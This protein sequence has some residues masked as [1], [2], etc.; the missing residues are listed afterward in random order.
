MRSSPAIPVYRT[1]VALAA[2]ALF[3]LAFPPP[4]TTADTPDDITRMIHAGMT[5]A[6]EARVGKPD[7]A[8]EHHW[9]AQ[10]YTRRA[11]STADPQQQRALWTE[12]DRHYAA[13][14]KRLHRATIAGGPGAVVLLAAARVE[15]GGIILSSQVARELDTYLIT[16]GAGG[17]HV[18]L[19]DRFAHARQLYVAAEQ[20][21]APLLADADR[22]EETLLAAGLYDT[23]RR[24]YFDLRLNHGW[25]CYYLAL[26]TDNATT[27]AT[28]LATA[29]G[30]FRELLSA[31]GP[32]QMRWVG[33]L[34][35]AM[36]QREQNHLGDAI[37]Q[38]TRALDRADALR[39][40]ARIRYELA[41]AQLRSGQ[42]DSARATLRPLVNEDPQQL[43]D[44]E[45]AAFYVNL[46]HLWHANSYLREAAW[47]ER[48][49]RQS[50]NPHHKLQDARRAQQRGLARFRE[51]EARGG[52]WPALVR[53]YVAQHIDPTQTAD[54]AAPLE[55]Y[56]AARALADR[57]ELAAAIDRLQTAL[58][59]S[60]DETLVP[61]LLFELGRC[62][63][64]QGALRSAARAFDQL[65]TE[66]RSNAR[67][68]QAATYAYQLW[69]RVA[70][71]SQ[72]P[73]DYANLA[74]TLRNLLESF[75][76]HADHTQA[77]WLL[78]AA[79]ERAGRFDDAA[80]QFAK[81]PHDHPRAAQ[82][83]LRHL[84]CQR[85]ALDQHQATLGTDRYHS[86]AIQLAEQLLA[87]AR[88]TRRAADNDAQPA[89]RLRWSAE[90]CVAAAELLADPRV[91]RYEAA[92]AALADFEQ[93]YPASDRTGNV[94][95]LRIRAHRGQQDFA[96]AAD[97]LQRYLAQAPADEIGGTLAALAQ[98]VHDE[99]DRLLAADHPDDA[100]ALA[101]SA[102]PT[103]I[104]LDEWVCADPQRAQHRDV[105][106]FA[107]ARMHHAAGQLDQALRAINELRARGPDNGRYQQRYARILTDLLAADANATSVQQVRDA[108]AAL[109]ADP[110]LRDRAP[111]RYWQARYHWLALTLRAG[112]AR[113]VEK[114]IRAERAWYPDLGGD[115]WQPKLTVLYANACRQLGIEPHRHDAT[116]H[117]AA[118]Q[119]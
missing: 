117:P 88:Q 23:L 3:T 82:A 102:M 45:P 63:Y 75:A 61:D 49:A 56:Y 119:P 111:E 43:A 79:L 78:P 25:A 36:T 95:A 110:T 101:R 68:P 2:L 9:L 11:Q 40:D 5:E 74:A 26:L 44:D 39:A 15:H 53:Q 38:F 103:F 55:L 19:R 93:H 90:A 85:K 18:W 89:E 8:D 28:L 17:D 92:L 30:R 91:A 69:G 80:R 99:V 106:L 60:D 54:D 77:V 73:A 52:P 27:R 86:R 37:E 57:N 7:T 32:E 35:L 105:V 22:H 47:I 84:L 10:A 46:A 1:G 59:R 107:R 4:R 98:D 104:A 81:I 50:T 97:V 67:A 12:A 83:R 16:D 14:I 48:R 21:L 113:T 87:Y 20:D 29:A 114:T 65:A 70:D 41:R 31:G 6:L 13:R 66:H 64:R 51:L 62:H 96:R 108:W 94:L 115:P 42:F 76:D 100:A 116:T 34:A 118:D 58:S 112:D 24:T 109:L 33:H 71:A 72:D